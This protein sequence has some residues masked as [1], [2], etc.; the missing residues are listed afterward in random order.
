MIFRLDNIS[1]RSE[2]IAPGNEVGLASAIAVVAPKSITGIKK[3]LSSF[4]FNEIIL[5][6]RILLTNYIYSNYSRFRFS[7]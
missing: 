2:E 6:D 7:R 1:A 4:H 5:F 3:I